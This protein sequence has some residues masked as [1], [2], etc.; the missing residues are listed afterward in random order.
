MSNQSQVADR[1]VDYEL[2]NEKAK[3]ITLIYYLLKI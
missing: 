2:G 1:S 3:E